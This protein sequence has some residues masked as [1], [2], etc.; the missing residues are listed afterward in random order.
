M[1]KLLALIIFL[2]LIILIP[3]YFTQRQ[4]DAYNSNNTPTT[5]NVQQP[6][7]IPTPTPTV[8]PATPTPLP[9]M[10]NSLQ[11]PSFR[12]NGGGDD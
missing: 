6:T 7:N 2:F 11:L 12:V 9:P 3:N 10:Q 4:T 5:Q 1:R 8:I